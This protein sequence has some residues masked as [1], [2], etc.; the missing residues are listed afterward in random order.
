MKLTVHARIEI[1]LATALLLG[2]C[3]KPE[4]EDRLEVAD[5]NARRAINRVDELESR[6]SDIEG[7]F[8][9]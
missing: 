9:M 6:V 3:S 8:G 2:S 1:A 5:V 7:K 4:W